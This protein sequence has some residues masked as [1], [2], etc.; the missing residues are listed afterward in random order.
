VLHPATRTW[1]PIRCAVS[2]PVEGP[3]CL[4]S[5][6]A[7]APNTFIL[8]LVHAL[9]R[10][11]TDPEDNLNDPRHETVDETEARNQGRRHDLV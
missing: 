2:W 9:S 3:T 8:D 6:H 5:K 1:S 4:V 10:V 7:D 11:P